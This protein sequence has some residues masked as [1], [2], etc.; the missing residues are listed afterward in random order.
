MITAH[1]YRDGRL[2]PVGEALEEAIW[3]DLFQPSEAELDRTAPLAAGAALPRLADM[4]EIEISNR[5]YREGDV[6]VVTVMLPSVEAGETVTSGPVTFML[7]PDRLITLRHHAPR[8]FETYPGRA[9]KSGFGCSTPDTVALGLM[10][11][12]VAR[13]ADLLERAGDKLDGVSRAVLGSPGNGGRRENIELQSVL[14]RIAREGDT[15]SRLRLSLLTMERGLGFLMHTIATPGP[16]GK[17]S[18]LRQVISAQLADIHALIEHA[19]SLSSKVSLVLSAT[20]GMIGLEQNDTVRT[21][22]VV[23]ALF[24]PPTLIASLYGMNFAHMPE[25]G[26]PWGYPVALGLMLASAG[27]TYL[28][29]KRRGWL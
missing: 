27:L 15:L 21:V 22:S 6:D 24:L 11:E 10:E 13:L 28:F 29:F 18:P 26:Q 4:Q 23:A 1:A 5:L 16:K 12:I 8:P 3:I 19:D 17:E 14:E 9:N 20:L 25:L 2:I 7:G